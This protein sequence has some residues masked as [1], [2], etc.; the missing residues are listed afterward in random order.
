[1]T[2]LVTVQINHHISQTPDVNVV[3]WI[4]TLCGLVGGYQHFRGIYHLNHIH[5]ED[6]CH[7]WLI[8][9]YNLESQIYIS[10]SRNVIAHSTK[11]F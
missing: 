4:V 2:V 10:H 1:V 9:Y 3:F 11:Y 5:P 7:I 6:R 8:S